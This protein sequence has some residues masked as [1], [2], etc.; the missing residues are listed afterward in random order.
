MLISGKRCCTLI[1]LIFGEEKM[2]ENVCSLFLVMSVTRL[3]PGA[4]RPGRGLNQIPAANCVEFQNKKNT[5][6]SLN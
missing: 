5:Q 2:S 1:V 6:L 3:H 4:L